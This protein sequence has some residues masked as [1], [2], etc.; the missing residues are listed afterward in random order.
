M[1][2]MICISNNKRRN[3]E[4]KCCIVWRQQQVL[5]R[6]GVDGGLGD[7]RLLVVGLHPCS[8]CGVLS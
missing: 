1:Q 8:F 5:N 4:E 7:C 3:K 2:S 6:A